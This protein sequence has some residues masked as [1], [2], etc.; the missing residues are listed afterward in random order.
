M[1]VV[2]RVRNSLVWPH[3]SIFSRMNSNMLPEKLIIHFDV[4]KTIIFVDPAGGKSTEDLVNGSL[5]QY[6]YGNILENPKNPIKGEDWGLFKWE[7]VTDKPLVDSPDPKLVSYVFYLDQV[8]YPDLHFDSSVSHSERL[9]LTTQLKAKRD[10]AKNKFTSPGFPGEHL[11]E[12]YDL[13]LKK[14]SSK[15]IDGKKK[16]V[17]L[18]PSFFYTLIELTK[19]NLNWTYVIRTFGSDIDDIAQEIDS[20]CNGTHP[21]HPVVLFNGQNGSRDLRVIN[22]CD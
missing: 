16:Y 13:F 20:F 5:A 12:F 11:V 17:F 3:W 10:Y 22:L 15:S 18:L 4:N 1:T 2:V 19:R 14:L 7:P 21:D 8:L 9:K 6:F